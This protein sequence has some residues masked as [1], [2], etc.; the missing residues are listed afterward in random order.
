MNRVD[1]RLELI[2]AGLVAAK[3]SLDDRLALDEQGASGMSVA[4]ILANR[5]ASEQRLGSARL[6]R[7]AL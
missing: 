7:P 1:C 4:R 2:R 3:A 5:I 6:V